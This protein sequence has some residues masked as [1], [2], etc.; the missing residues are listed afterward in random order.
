MNTELN[1]S[2]AYLHPSLEQVNYDSPGDDQDISKKYSLFSLEQS[3]FSLHSQQ[4]AL[5][6][7]EI[8]CVFI[9]TKL[10]FYFKTYFS[11]R[12]QMSRSDMNDT[13]H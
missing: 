6:R 12:I 3:L 13:N 4:Y 10:R 1:N 5:K 8:P 11:Q 7:R 2:T 9:D